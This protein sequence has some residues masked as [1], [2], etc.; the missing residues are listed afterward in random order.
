MDHRAYWTVAAAGVSLL[1]FLLRR[2]RTKSHPPFPPGPSRDP[3]IGSLRNFPQVRWPE[4][5][6]NLQK[7]YG[8]LIYFNILGQPLLVVNSLGDAR[9]LMEKR[10]NIHSGRPQ[11]V[12]NY[13]V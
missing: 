2:S 4:A 7:V 13:T 11:D 5:F 3:I 1:A 8:D 12:M 6:S 9:E 10:G